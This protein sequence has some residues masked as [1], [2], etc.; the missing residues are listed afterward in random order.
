MVVEPSLLVV[1]MATVVGV[2]LV[3]PPL[4]FLF[5]DT[6]ELVDDVLDV[7][8]LVVGVV[9]VVTPVPTT[10]RLGMMPSGISWALIVAK[11]RPKTK[12]NMMVAG[13]A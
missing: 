12:A 9:L 6:E 1:V 2:L 13:H 4:L 7:V 5:V 11:S 8:L 10:C 3:V